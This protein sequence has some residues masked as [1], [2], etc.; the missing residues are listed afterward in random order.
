MKNLACLIAVLIVA[1]VPTQGGE[2]YSLRIGNV[3]GDADPITIG[4]REMARTVD[5]RTHGQVKIEVYPSSRLGDTAEILEQA[6]SGSAVGV[7]IDTG[8]LAA[9]VPEMAIYTAPYVF[10]NIRDA[11]NF[12][13]TPMFAEW[14]GELVR[15][16][17]RD[18]SCNW[19][20]GARHFL[21]NVRV[22]KPVDLANLRVRTM[23]SEVAQESMRAFGA[24]PA[25]LAWSKV[26]EGLRTD[27]I[28]AA[29]AQLSAAHGASLHEVIKFVAETGHFILNTALVT[30][31]KWFASLPEEY[32][33]I[34]RNESLRAGDYATSLTIEREGEFKSDMEDAGVVF[35][36]V[37][38]KPFI[39]ASKAVYDVMDWADLKRRIDLAIGK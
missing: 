11:R 39:E 10:D 22:E 9:Y 28:D 2:S 19:Y 29:E 31:E 3:L 35:T 13:E 18:L 16:G 6:I 32:R 21:T 27:A 1:W 4:L 14:D 33:K 30:S 38:I 36:T 24:I 15:Y 25:T 5:S 23:G 26:Y 34:L 37:D 8:M 7:I 20:Q 12:I 17:I